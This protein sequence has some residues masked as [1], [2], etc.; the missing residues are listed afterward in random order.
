MRKNNLVPVEDL[1][2]HL[3]NPEVPEDDLPNNIVQSMNSKKPFADWRPAGLKAQWQGIKQGG[4]EL[5]QGIEQGGA[6][7]GKLVGLE[8]PSDYEK[9]TNQIKQ[10]RDLWAQNQGTNPISQKMRSR[11]KATPWA[12]AMPFLGPELTLAN[13]AKSAALGGGIGATQFVPPGGSRGRN[14]AIGAL[15][16]AAVPVSGAGARGAGRIVKS[17]FNKSSPQKT[18]SIIQGGHDFLD[19]QAGELYDYVS[20]EA[21]QR[22]ID[23]MPIPNKLIEDTERFFPNTEASRNLIKKSKTGDYESIRKLQ[24]DLR[25]R[26]EKLKSSD[27]AAD[28]DKGE[29]ALDTRDK[30]N[31]EVA[32]TFDVFGHSDL[33]EKLSEANNIYRNLKDT[34][35]SHPTISKLVNPELRKVPK[36]INDT[37]MEIS[38][39]MEKVRNAHPELEN[40]V[41][42]AKQKKDAMELLKK[43][44]LLSTA[45]VGGGIGLYEAGKHISLLKSLLG[46]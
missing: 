17:L 23:K 7:L 4:R 29:E 45:S 39:P 8:S 19:K 27:Y 35:Y 11:T 30:L 32:D 20:N 37:V 21:K 14:I 9:L 33:K 12:A 15:E 40:E 28:R 31:K 5:G 18:A 10:Q 41:K 25:K 44:G 13:V 46:N 26:G 34:Y 1:P 3:L 42:L 6:W 22:G 36:N 2:D 43:L 38:K 24:S 16:G